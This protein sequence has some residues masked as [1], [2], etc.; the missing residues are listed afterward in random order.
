M[1]FSF[2]HQSDEHLVLLN[3]FNIICCL[4]NLNCIQNINYAFL[5]T[6]NLTDTPDKMI[7][8]L[9]ITIIKFE[10]CYKII[11]FEI[12]TNQVGYHRKMS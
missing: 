12:H 1:W 9:N 2:I 7:N 6:D 4:N 5:K 3:N 8:K 10:C 11:Y